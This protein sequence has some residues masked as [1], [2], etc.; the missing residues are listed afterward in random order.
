MGKYG[1]FNK[2]QNQKFQYG[3]VFLSYYINISIFIL[4][5]DVISCELLWYFWIIW[6]LTFQLKAL[7]IREPSIIKLKRLIKIPD[8][9][10]FWSKFK[11]PAL[12]L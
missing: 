7:R 12:K 3:Y 1:V 11:I 5:Q 2:N 8:I 9:A 6:L 10:I 4:I